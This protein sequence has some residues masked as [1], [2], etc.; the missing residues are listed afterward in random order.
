MSTANVTGSLLLAVAAGLT[1]FGLTT[2][3]HRRR[4]VTAARS[5][6]GLNSGD[7]TSDHRIRI[8]GRLL[9]AAVTAAFVGVFAA[10]P[11]GIVLAPPPSYSLGA[12]P[13]ISRD[14]A[15][16]FLMKRSAPRFS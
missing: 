7:E 11:L 8:D 9:L 1:V 16:R 12:G 13:N 2:V 15:R 6:V 4:I 10:G 5:Q 3:R 14:A